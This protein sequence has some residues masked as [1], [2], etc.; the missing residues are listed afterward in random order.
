M[1]GAGLNVPVW[2]LG[3]SLFSAQLAGMLGLPYAFASHFAPDYLMDALAIY[4]S[5]F[6]P[7]Q[8]LAKPYVM[9]GTSVVGADSEEEARRLFTSQQGTVGS[10]DARER[11]K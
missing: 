7:S 10:D 9:V 5:E 2:L 6:R 4:R 3:S 1:P 11:E 8:Q